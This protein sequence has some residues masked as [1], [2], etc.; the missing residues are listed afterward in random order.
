MSLL[1]E[2]HLDQIAALGFPTEPQA[3]VETKAEGM[4]QP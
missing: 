3:V 1:R 4:V 2:V